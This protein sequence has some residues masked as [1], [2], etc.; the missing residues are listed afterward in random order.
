MGFY[1]L[2]ERALALEREGRKIVRLNVG[3]TNLPTPL[4]AV[5]AAATRM[6][7][8]KS[9]YGP[10]AGL[11]ELREAVAGREGCKAANVVVGPGSKHL[12][13]GLMSILCRGGDSVAF[14]SPHWPMYELA[15]SQL[16]L[17]M[18]ALQSGE[19]DG[20]MFDASGL[21]GAKLSIIC[22]P[23][24]PTSTI[25]REK[26]IEA[27]IEEAQ[28]EGTHV[29][30][31]EAYKGLAFREI[32]VFE[33]AIRVRSF[34]KEFNMEG[35]RLGYAVAPEDVAKRLTA[36]NQITATCVAPF[37]QEAGRAALAEEKKILEGNR[38]IWKKRAEAAAKALS[39]AGFRFAKPEAGIYL[40][41]SHENVKDCE[42][43]SLALLEKEGVCVAPG[44]GFGNYRKHI[45]ICVNQ[46]EQVLEA[47]IA[48]MGRAAV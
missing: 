3:D 2:A 27:A 30:L 24:N 8:G 29:I 26:E 33:G 12:I 43:F 45:R 46:E 37:V 18:N 16:G 1:E 21:R 41:A 15:C 39:D 10:S 17:K 6:R 11:Q 22:N 19:A 20:W 7:Q 34:S 42:K 25:Y 48:K 4:C 32:P 47:A 36:Y 9:G 23:L 14:P 38:R 44:T 13:Y 31:D 28:R 5:E 35:W 40:F